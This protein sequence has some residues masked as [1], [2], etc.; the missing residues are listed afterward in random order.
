[1]I[2]LSH[3]CCLTTQVL[4]SANCCQMEVFNQ[5]LDMFTKDQ[6]KKDVFPPTMSDHRPN[7]FCIF[8]LT[9]KSLKKFQFNPCVNYFAT[10][11]GAFP[12]WL[13]AFI[14][15]VRR[16]QT[17][18]AESISSRLTFLGSLVSIPLSHL[19]LFL[20][21]LRCSVHQKDQDT[22]AWQRNPQSSVCDAVLINRLCLKRPI[23]PE[24]HWSIWPP[25]CTR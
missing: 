23:S 3:Y 18:G 9:K 14:S 22:A 5:C 4:S 1:M 25:G 13:G 10:N 7:I 6:N 20:L 19:Q 2:Q 24:C 21:A 11:K 12:L 8:C 15:I 17:T 16:K